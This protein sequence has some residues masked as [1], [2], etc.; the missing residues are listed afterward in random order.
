M[1][2]QYIDYGF[3][4]LVL[5]IIL[6]AV[7]DCFP[8]LEGVTDSEREMLLLHKD[9]AEIFL[10]GDPDTSLL[11]MYLEF[12]GVRMEPPIDPVEV[13]D[14]LK[15]AGYK[16]PVGAR[17]KRLSREQNDNYKNKKS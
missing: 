6:L 16:K 8:V 4:W 17:M 3:T 1:S 11:C 13:R 5:D 2:H 10:R 7:N 12:L 15:D 14:K 9:R